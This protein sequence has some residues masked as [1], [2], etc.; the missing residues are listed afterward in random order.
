MNWKR[1]LIRE[2]KRLFY[3]SMTI[4]ALLLLFKVMNYS[5]HDH[6][7]DEDIPYQTYFNEHYRIFSL[8]L[9]DSMKLAGESVPMKDL[10]VR[11]KLDR[12]LL[13]N[14]YWQSHSLLLHKR[15]HR[16]FPVIEPI[17][18]AEGVPQDLKYIAM[19]E[20]GLQNVVSP[21]GAEGVWQFMEGTAKE[22][23]LEVNENVD[24]RYH[25]RKA[26]RAACK[27]LKKAREKYSS[28]TLA[29]A[30]YNVGSAALD[31]RI[32][33]QKVNSYYQLLL[34][35]ETARYIYRILALK[36]IHQNPSKYGFHLREQDLYKPYETRTVEVDSS[37][38][39]LAQFALDQGANFKA[40]KILNPWLREDHLE[41]EEGNT[42][43]IELP[44]EMTEEF[45]TQDT[46][47]DQVDSLPER[48]EKDSSPVIEEEP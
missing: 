5:S 17:L 14:T 44:V 39:D 21:A 48:I 36:E 26:T 24:E 25:V 13:V 11:E 47:E 35:D 18:E 4:L 9:P 28:W 33:R 19:A 8:Q 37:I 42:Y 34:N 23:G 7:E 22:L 29:V 40:L 16:W 12:E 31:R 46:L 27:Y 3:S 6:E 43:K 10:D 15:A 41:N 38:E 32:M 1:R 2:G 30:A 45:I 20:S